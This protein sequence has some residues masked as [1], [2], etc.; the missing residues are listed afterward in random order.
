MSALLAERIPLHLS[1][2]HPPILMVVIDTEEEFDWFQP[3]DRANTGVTAMAAA[4]R[5]QELFDEFGIRPCWVVDYPVASQEAGWKPLA[6]IVES[7][8]ASIGAHLHPWVSPPHH[9]AVNPANSYPGNLPA[10]LQEEKL[11]RLGG[12]IEDAFGFQPSIYKAGRYGF[13]PATTGV[14]ESLGYEIDLSPCPGFDL[15][16]DGGPDWAA[17]PPD[18][19]RFGRGWGLVGLPTSGGFVGAFSGA[20]PLLHRLAHRPPFIWGR[21]PGILSR[22]GLLERLLLSPE[23]Y[24]LEHLKRLTRAL[25]ARGTRILSFSLHSPSLE[26]GH[27]PYVR[28]ESDLKEFLATCRQYFE[29]FLGELGGATMGPAEVRQLLI[30]PPLSLDTPPNA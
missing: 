6:E 23:G 18:P 17:F 22:L 8:R 28:S 1:D 7:G 15:T 27:T 19:Y 21:A 3:F 16:G 20:G 5:G 11:R 14:L 24:E 2:D 13:G 30:D 9:E 4:G 29:Y 26:P 25:I 10:Q 12:A